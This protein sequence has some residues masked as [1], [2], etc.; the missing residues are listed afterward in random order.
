MSSLKK[1][2]DS[3][4]VLRIIIYSINVKFPDFI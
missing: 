2:E 1:M 3:W 4:A